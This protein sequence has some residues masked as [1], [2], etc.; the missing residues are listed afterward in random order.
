[1]TS[2]VLC[3]AMKTT[4]EIKE[5]EINIL[6]KMKDVVKNKQNSIRVLLVK[7]QFNRTRNNLNIYLRKRNL[8]NRISAKKQIQGSQIKKKKDSNRQILI[9]Y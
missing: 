4:M 8:L 5:I 6:R 7:E 2:E 1:M 3:N 9:N